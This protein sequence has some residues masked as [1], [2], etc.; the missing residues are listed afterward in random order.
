M[1]YM[2]PTIYTTQMESDSVK[3]R[4]ADLR[5]EFQQIK[6]SRPSLLKRFWNFLTSK[7]DKDLRNN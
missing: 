5:K 6:L 3:Q 1:T 7:K 2:P 4:T